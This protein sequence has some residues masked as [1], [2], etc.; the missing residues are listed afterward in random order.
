MKR[1]RSSSTFLKFKASGSFRIHGLSRV[2]IR[3]PDSASKVWRFNMF[4]LLY[5]VSIGCL[6]MEC[7]GK[8]DQTRETRKV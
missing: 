5:N 4:I 8:G 7:Q 1:V 2:E 3:Q 6:F